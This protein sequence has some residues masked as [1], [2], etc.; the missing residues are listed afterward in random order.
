M[1]RLASVE[2][3]GLQERH[4][5]FA[6]ELEG[7]FGWRLGPPGRGVATDPVP[8]SRSFRAK[9]ADDNRL[10]LELYDFARG[11]IERRSRK[12]SI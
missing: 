2:A 12:A 8:V 4:E 10:D 11:L 7:R 9:I 6:R 5:D 3:V 1:S